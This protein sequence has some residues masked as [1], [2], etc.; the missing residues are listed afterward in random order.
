MGL[1]ESGWQ[2]EARNG[3]MGSAQRGSTVL[4]KVNSLSPET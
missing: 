2:T 4:P 1:L 3:L